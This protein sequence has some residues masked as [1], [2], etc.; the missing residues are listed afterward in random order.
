[1]RKRDTRQLESPTNVTSRVCA[2]YARI[3]PTPETGVGANYSIASQLH[4]M[5][6]H[7]KRQGWTVAEESWTTTSAGPHWTALP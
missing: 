5:R 7:A 2:L 1:M 3:S 4:E 6:E